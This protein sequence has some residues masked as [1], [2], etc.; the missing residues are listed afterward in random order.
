MKKVVDYVAGGQQTTTIAVAG[1]QET[2]HIAIA[3]TTSLP[4]GVSM[5]VVILSTGQ[6]TVQFNNESGAAADPGNATIT[7][8]V[9]GHAPETRKRRAGQIKVCPALWP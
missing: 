8:V 9:L 3:N 4:A 6:V 5:S 2:G 7:V 1:A